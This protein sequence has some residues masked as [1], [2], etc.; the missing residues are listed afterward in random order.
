MGLFLDITFFDAMIDDRWKR[1]Y[2]EE[3]MEAIFKNHT[4]SLVKLPQ[5]HKPI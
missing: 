3:E 5:G 4:W 1:T 2:M